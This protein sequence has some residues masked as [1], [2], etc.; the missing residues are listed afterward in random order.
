MSQSRTARWSASPHGP[1]PPASSSWKIYSW[2]RA[3]GGAVSPRRL[4]AA[5]PRSCG[6][7]APGGHC[8]SSGAGVLPR[9][10]LHRLRRRGNRLRCRAPHGPRALLRAAVPSD[11]GA[12]R[13]QQDDSLARRHD[14]ALG[15]PLPA[16]RAA[17]PLVMILAAGCAC[18]G[19]AACG[20]GS[21]VNTGLACTSAGA[22]GSSPAFRSQYRP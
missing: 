10:R 5:S 19:S 17:Y 18:W 1:R 3:I 15:V 16:V 8:Q 20:A 13:R 11:L 6:R 4:S 22:T 9:R 21:C 14:S 7:G 2:T 12:R